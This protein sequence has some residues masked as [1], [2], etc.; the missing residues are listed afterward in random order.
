MDRREFKKSSLF[1]VIL[2]VVI[3]IAPSLAWTVEL[4]DGMDKLA[5]LL[6]K[7][8]PEHRR[9]TVA[10]TDFPDLRGVTSDLGRFI[11]ERLTTHPNYFPQLVVLFSPRVLLKLGHVLERN[12]EA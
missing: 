1:F 4:K 8:V 7:G 12:I 3:T 5:I 9:M 2:L 6:A 10:V 11:G